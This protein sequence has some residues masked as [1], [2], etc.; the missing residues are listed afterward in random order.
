M[1]QDKISIDLKLHTK[2]EDLDNPLTL[3]KKKRDFLSALAQTRI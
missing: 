1:Q 3:G 2:W